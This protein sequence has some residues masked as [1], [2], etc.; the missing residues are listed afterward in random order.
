MKLYHGSQYEIKIPLYNGS[1]LNNDYG[2]GFYCTESIELAK[3][4]GCSEEKDGFANEYDLDA[5]NL[6]VLD[7]NN[8]TFTILNWLAILLKNRSFETRSEIS[9]AAKD[10]LLQNFLINFEGYDVIKGYRADDSYFSFANSFLNNS[11]SLQKLNVAMKLGKLGEQIV[12][13]SEKSFTKINFVKSHVSS[14]DIYYPKKVR[15]D[16]DARTSFSTLKLQSELTNGIFML[17]IIR[18]DLKNESIQS[19]LS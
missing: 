6:T 5:E 9:I 17:D 16:F 2:Q 8:P 14:K 13:K 7:L 10:Y 4:W 15:R 1:K 12:L 19:I 18:Q 3:E 11:I